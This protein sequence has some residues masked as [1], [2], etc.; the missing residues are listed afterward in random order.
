MPARG[1]GRRRHRG[2]DA[3]ATGRSGHRVAFHDPLARDHYVRVDGNDYSIHPSVMGRR[4]EVVA[5][6]TTVTATCDGQ[7]VASHDR[8][9]ANIRVSPV[10]NRP[11]HLVTVARWRE[12]CEVY[13]RLSMTPGPSAHTAGWAAKRGYAPP[14]AWD[15]DSIDDPAARPATD[16]PVATDAQVIDLVAIRRAIESPDSS[17]PLTKPER[18]VAASA[19][20]ALGLAD[21]RI[22]ERLGFSDRTVLRWRQADSGHSPTSAA[23]ERDLELV[24]GNRGHPAPPHYW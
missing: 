17:P 5:D 24:G 6:L 20:A 3:A 10:L 19:L 21:G 13:D 15:E 14:L 2:D 9:W 18:I 12:V 16:R 23:A 11:G 7:V 8:S 22:G 1:L 4:I